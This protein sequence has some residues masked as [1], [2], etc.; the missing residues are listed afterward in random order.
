MASV[1][2]T[3]DSFAYRMALSCAF[4]IFRFGLYDD[5]NSVYNI[6]VNSARGNA[7]SVTFKFINRKFSARC[8]RGSIA[9]ENFLFAFVGGICRFKL[10]LINERV[11]ARIN[12]IGIVRLRRGAERLIV[13]AQS[14]YGR[15]SAYYPI[16]SDSNMAAHKRS[17]KP[18][19]VR[20]NIHL[21]RFFGD[22]GNAEFAA[23]VLSENNGKH[24]IR[25]ESLYSLV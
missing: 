13:F 18:T 14:L 20:E 7:L 3:A 21:C 19:V 11:R 4:V 10:Y 12:G 2:K 17:V 6:I 23:R 16:D 8:Q 9:G 25:I 1:G 5:H 24:I 22:R 15:L